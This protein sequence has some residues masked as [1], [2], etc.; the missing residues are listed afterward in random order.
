MRT[1]LFQ[2]SSENR[3]QTRVG[4]V[5][6]VRVRWQ[7]WRFSSQKGEEGNCGRAINAG[8]WGIYVIR[9][10]CVQ[11]PVRRNQEAGV[12]YR[13]Q[14]GSWLRKEMGSTPPEEGAALGGTALL[15][16]DTGRAGPTTRGCTSAEPAEEQSPPLI[17]LRCFLSQPLLF[18]SGID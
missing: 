10:T 1:E 15:P 14:K 7:R 2:G 4:D 5:R 8:R 18:S 16:C 17:Q 9:P 12:N 13:E 6:D 3:G 11:M